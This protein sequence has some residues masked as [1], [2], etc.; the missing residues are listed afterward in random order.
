MANKSRTDLNDAL[1]F[2]KVGDIRSA[3][4]ALISALKSDPDQ[5]TAWYL[6]SFT[7]PDTTQKITALRRSLHIKPGFEQ[8]QARL[9]S[10]TSTTPVSVYA[11]PPARS[12]LEGS[13]AEIQAE[14]ETENTSSAKD[15]LQVLLSEHPHDARVWY[16]VSFVETQHRSQVNALRHALRL[17]P[18]LEAARLR[19]DDLQTGPSAY[20][21]STTAIP[22]LT[23]I[24]VDIEDSPLTITQ[25]FRSFFS[26]G[27]YILRR[28]SVI[29]V[30]ILAGVY[31]TILIANYNNQIDT[32]IE[33]QID[34]QLRWMRYHGNLLSIPYEEREAIIEEI[35]LELTEEYGLNLPH[36][37][38]NL[39]WTWNALRFSWGDIL[40][41][42]VGSLGGWFDDLYSVNKIVLTHLPNTVLVI[43]TADFIIF[44]IGIPLALY[45]ATRKQ[46]HWLDRLVAMLSPISSVPSWVHGIILM[47]I[48]AIQLKLLPY[49]GKYDILPAE[50][51]LGNALV[52]AKHMVLPVMAVVLGLFFQLVASWRTYFMIYTE[53]DYVDLAKAKG[54]SPKMIERQYIL[55][56]TIP[57]I[58][59]SFGL[60]LVSF[61]Q[62]T[63]ALEHIFDWPGIGY[64]YIRSLPH[65][66]G[67][68]M[69]PGEM[70]IVICIVVIFAYLLGILVFTLDIIYAWIDPRIRMISENQ[71]VTSPKRHLRRPLRL[72]FRRKPTPTSL[73][74]KTSSRRTRP[75]IYTLR[76][77]FANLVRTIKD[78]MVTSRRI[79]VE[80]LRFPS[81]VFGLAIIVIF[82]V[83]SAYAV[84]AMPYM[85]IGQMWSRES[86]TGRFYVPRNVPAQ[87]VN[88][89]RIR[90]L[91]TT[92]FASSREG[93]IQKEIA[94]TEGDIG[95]IIFTTSIDYPYREFPQELI[96]Y[97]DPIFTQK[98]PHVTITWTTPDGRVFQPKSPSA[99]AVLTYDFSEYIFPR[100][101]VR[102]NEH[103]SKWFVIDDQNQT[104][105]FYVLFAD[106]NANEPTALPGRYQ[107][108]VTTTTFEPGTDMELEFVLMG[109]VY[110]WAGTDYLRRD[111]TVPLLW[112]LP[113]ALGFGL[114]GSIVTTLIAMILAAAGVW[115]G[116]WID[117]LIQQLTE[118]NMIFP[119]LAIGILLY[120]IYHISLWT[121]LI[122]I[123]LL[124]I[125]G[126]PTKAFRAAFLQIREAP[127]IEAAQAYGA[128][129]RRIIFKYM[130]PRV[131]PVMIPQLVL[132]MPSL[133]FLEATLGIMNVQDPRFPTWGRVLFEALTQNA[134]WGGMEYWVLEPLALL[135]LTGLAFTLFGFG[136]ERVLNPRLLEK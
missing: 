13:L 18:D 129:N 68:T 103:W 19:L 23:S 113:F 97:I 123:V 34:G 11:H 64:L 12:P 124:G 48:F 101:Y 119:V 82:L 92:Q 135:L 102:D 50:T 66:W 76:I 72:S 37:L 85:Q 7:L 42:Q 49:G 125:F 31:L 89:F 27:R 96:L 136:L 70:S 2:L 93:S 115:F 24:P 21:S 81:A 57:Y 5:A 46:G 84:L 9:D 75:S 17:D 55:R 98:Y 91:P 87:W 79:L 118:I 105:E 131:V 14:I 128:T 62:M 41:H 8:A 132:L 20:P 58:V 108:Q 117:R 16:L 56:P 77:A 71:S 100:T 59:T 126:G 86:L 44:S 39:R 36:Y 121:I 43:G 110:G 112:G 83:G 99:N 63:T 111:L 22:R 10:L 78:M 15:K 25:K 29:L 80:V 107:L 106:P 130:I 122:A 30:T 38:R 127:Y 116:G 60:T 32:G 45:L 88:W 94:E 73:T 61:W 134:L 26:L 4:N 54:L 65:F 133:V 47:M 33:N 3:Q 109:R 120:A 67:E 104:P 53:E 40:Y 51:W 52:V 6:L 28:A 90:D 1:Q 114:V 95:E 69:F 74:N 35:R